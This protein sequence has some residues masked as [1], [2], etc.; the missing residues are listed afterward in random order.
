VSI[1]T[2]RFRTC[3]KRFVTD[4]EWKA[5]GAG[6]AVDQRRTQDRVRQRKRNCSPRNLASSAANERSDAVLA[7]IGPQYLLRIEYREKPVEVALTRRGEEGI[8]DFSLTCDIGVRSRNG[9]TLHDAAEG[10]PVEF[11]TPRFPT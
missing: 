7:T 1:T 5:G 6:G 11:A 4:V 2:R 9:C 3:Y 10:R 8:D